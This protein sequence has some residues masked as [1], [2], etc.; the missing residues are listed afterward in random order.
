MPTAATGTTLRSLTPS[1][2]AGAAWSAAERMPPW[3]FNGQVNNT[4]H[5]LSLLPSPPLADGGSSGGGLRGTAEHARGRRQGGGHTQVRNGAVAPEISPA[6]WGSASAGVIG[7]RRPSLR[8]AAGRTSQTRLHGGP[9]R[10][11]Q[12]G[13]GQRLGVCEDSIEATAG[14]LHHCDGSPRLGP[15]HHR[16]AREGPGPA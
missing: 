10:I 12:A 8:R 16:V 2:A 13:A 7:M 11:N 15:S 3:A 4:L 9:A 14:P 1:W 5:S 6:G